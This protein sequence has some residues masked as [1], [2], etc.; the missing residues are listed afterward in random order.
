LLSGVLAGGGV[1][2]VLVELSVVEQRYHAVMEVLTTSLG[3]NEVARRYGVSRQSVRNWVRRYEEGGLEA[4]SDRSRRPKLSPGRL[5]PVA[6]AAI[7][8]LRLAHPRWG[9]RRIAHELARS[10]RRPPA[11]STIYRVL[12]RHHLVEPVARRQR[13]DYTS[14]ERSA[15]MELWQLDITGKAFLCDGTE[16]KI[17]TGIDDHSR[18]CVLAKVIRRQTSRAV[19]EAFCEAVAC[20]GVPDEVLSDNGVQFTG[21]FDS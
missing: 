18:F 10:G 17:V 2:A 16:L 8:D 20:Y 3:V 11:R 9:P 6:E 4:L 13:K 15:P 12:V 5:P 7:V 14:F 1:G 21:R 19:V